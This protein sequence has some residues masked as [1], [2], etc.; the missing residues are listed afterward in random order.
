MHYTTILVVIEFLT[1]YFCCLCEV[2]LTLYSLTFVFTIP[3]V[4]TECTQNIEELVSKQRVSKSNKNVR[5]GAGVSYFSP[6]YGHQSPAVVP[7]RRGRAPLA[8][9]AQLRAQLRILLSQ[10]QLY[11]LLIILTK[12]HCLYS[13]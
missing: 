5:R 10:V 4:G 12:T 1:F 7:P 8:L 13:L 3:A 2:A 6:L 11:F 9:P